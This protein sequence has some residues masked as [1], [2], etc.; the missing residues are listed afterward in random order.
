MKIVYCLNSIR[1]LG[2]IQRV[3]LVKAN[4]LADVP[5][6]EVYI[7]V[8]DNARGELIHPLSPKVTLVDLQVNYYEDDWKSRWNVLKGIVLKRRE[9]KK[10]LAKAL[11]LIR[12]D[13]VVSVGQS[14]KNM[15]P[16]IPGNWV[17]VRELHFTK[18]YRRLH[19]RTWFERIS[20]F[21]GDVYDYRYKIKGYNRI[22]VLTQEDK[23]ENWKNHPHVSVIPN[24]VSFAENTVLSDLNA[25]KITTVGRLELQKNYAS[26]VR[27]FRLVADHHPDWTLEIYGEGTQKQELLSLISRLKLSGN[28][29][30]KGYTA[31]VQEK[32]SKASAFVLSSIFEGLPLVIIEAMSCGLPVVSYACSCGPQDIIADG[33]DG[34]LIP[35]N[36]EKA[37]ADRICR[38]I[39]D[40]DLRHRMG[41]AALKKAEQYR[42]ENIIPMW[43][44]LFNEL[45]KKKR[46]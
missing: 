5:G 30:L 17:T 16:S 41:E 10:R 9:H 22:V 12:P 43:M 19:S 38:L 18:N 27:A 8:S 29:F 45:L 39:E 35:V 32:I 42:I 37:L 20:A 21:V 3:T 46:P 7:L 34:Y 11:H 36:D 4:A 40:E 2:G 33:H 44:E 14:E 25:K 31:Q 26:L 24:P 23:T 28:V 6:N 13:V 15:L 1:Y